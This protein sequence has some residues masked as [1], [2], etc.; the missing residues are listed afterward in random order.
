MDVEQIDE[1]FA[2]PGPDK[3]FSMGHRRQIKQEFISL[4]FRMTD[5]IVGGAIGTTIG[6]TS[7]WF[8]IKWLGEK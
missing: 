6:A 1:A 2:G 5:R 8:L 7:A 4:C 3:P